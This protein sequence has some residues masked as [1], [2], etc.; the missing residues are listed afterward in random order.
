MS[1]MPS[2]SPIIF[3]SE[4]RL[5]S[6]L[7][8]RIRLARKRRHL[9]AV[10]V[11]QRAGISRSSLHKVECGDAA[12]TL[13]VYLRVLATM[14]LEGGIEAMAADDKVGRKLQDLALE[15]APR[16]PTARARTEPDQAVPRA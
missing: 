7:G 8:E 11:A 9:A 2:Q 5:L 13:G 10:A 4:Q 14:G 16:R 15:P 12:V 3:P 6:A 1:D